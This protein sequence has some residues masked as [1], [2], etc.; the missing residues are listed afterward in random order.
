MIVDFTITNFRSIRDEQTL[1]MHAQG[2]A[3][4]GDNVNFPGD[5]H[6]GV[7]RSVGIYGANASGKSNFLLA[8]HAL[9][10]IVGNTGNLQDGARIAC[11]EPY[12]LCSTT[13][14]API[15]F[16]VEFYFDGFRYL[17]RVSF[18]SHAILEESLDYYPSRH[19]ANLFN[20]T[21]SD[22]WE[23]ISF[24]G[25]LKGG[26]RKFALF[27]NNSYLSK[28]GNSADA[29]SII[30]NVFNFFS[31]SMVHLAVG[32]NF[33]V[34]NV[35]ESEGIRSIFATILSKLDTGISNIEVE[36]QE[37]KLLRTLDSA[38]TPEDM[39]EE[40]KA[41]LLKRSRFKP[42][43]LHENDSGGFER[44]SERME[45][46]GTVKLFDLLPLLISCFHSGSVLIIDEL[47]NSLHFHMAELII[48]LFHDPNVN[49]N[50]SQLIFSTH[51]IN[52]MSHEL[53]RRDQIWFCEKKLGVSAIASLD[54]F[55]KKVVKSDSP[56]AKW[57][58]EGRFGG[59]PHIDYSAVASLLSVVEG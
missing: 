47:D 49:K 42:F 6:I 40:L 3:V 1:S 24:G 22:T 54:Q 10:Y 17:Y 55:D 57:Y 36:D 53:M 45:S 34:S 13:K 30:R 11:Y 38:N 18:N 50:G 16:E 48:K 58:E 2:G 52:L 31:Y 33:K 46:S 20:R 26:R 19:K 27:K 15:N 25:H 8:L 4:L 7:L 43:F 51:N 12:L 44:F 41:E 28:A 32:E 23:T 35:L 5:E 37:E 39:R 56:F 59:I 21:E 14:N 29:P 9:Q